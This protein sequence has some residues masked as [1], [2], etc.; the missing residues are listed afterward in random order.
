MLSHKLIAFLT[1]ASVG[2]FNIMSQPEQQQVV[3]VDTQVPVEE[4]APYCVAYDDGVS[5]EQLV[6]SAAQYYLDNLPASFFDIPNMGDKEQALL[7]AMTLNNEAV[8]TVCPHHSDNAFT[9]EEFQFFMPEQP[10]IKLQPSPI[11]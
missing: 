2:I 6:T 8:T 5:R 4:L 7:L 9:P 10:R 3:N 11:Y 1:A